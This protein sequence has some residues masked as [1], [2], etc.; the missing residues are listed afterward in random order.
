MYTRS[1]KIK[2]MEKIKAFTIT[3][4]SSLELMARFFGEE[5]EKDVYA[6]NVTL[7]AVQPRTIKVTQKLF[8]KQEETVYTSVV[9]GKRIAL[10]GED[11]F[12][13]REEWDFLI[14]PFSQEFIKDGIQEKNIY[15][16]KG[17][18]KARIISLL[19]QG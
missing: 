18:M 6:S 12:R 17:K 10:S 9:F 13:R 4:D 3:L 19:K 14:D 5:K 1:I 15:K 11:N 16:V 2:N 8:F 7:E